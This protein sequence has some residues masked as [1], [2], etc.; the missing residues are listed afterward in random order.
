M[1]LELYMDLLSAPCRAVYIFARK[2]SIPFDFQFVDLL[3]GMTPSSWAGSRQNWL[4]QGHSKR[5][6]QCPAVPFCSVAILSYLCRKYSAPSHWYPPDL[7]TRARVD[8]FLAWQHTAVQLPMSKMLWIQLLIPMITGEEVPAQKTG[9]I[10][11]EVNNSLQLFEEKFLQDRLFIT[12]DHI[13]LADLVA[14]VAMMQPMGASYNVFNSPKLAEWR[15]RVEVAIGLSLFQE[16]HDRTTLVRV[17][18]HLTIR[19]TPEPAAQPPSQCTRAGSSSFP[20]TLS[21]TKHESHSDSVTRCC[22]HNHNSQGA[23]HNPQVGGKPRI[24]SLASPPL[25]PSCT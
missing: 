10:L 23:P 3:K 6:E 11:E 16:A 15:M 14:L 18:R 1:G 21:F 2:N 19:A 22:V 17:R 13:S 24:N 25:P 20:G 7:H 9:Q 12:G 4:A 8:E 5:P